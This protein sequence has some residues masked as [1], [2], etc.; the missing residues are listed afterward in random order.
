MSL[1]RDS[2]FTS[3]HYTQIFPL[4]AMNLAI[5]HQVVGDFGHTKRISRQTLQ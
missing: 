4:E 1:L 3:D 5:S 2:L